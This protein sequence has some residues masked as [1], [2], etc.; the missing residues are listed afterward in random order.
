MNRKILFAT[1]FSDASEEAF[2]Q[3]CAIGARDGAVVGIC[4]VLPRS[5]A[6]PPWLQ[7]HVLGEGEVEQ[8]TRDA[9]AERAAALGKAGVAKVETFV[10]KGDFHAAIVEQ[11]EAFGADR[12]LVGS[13]GR[14]GVARM[15]LGSVAEK[16]VRH[17]HCAVLVARPSPETGPVVAS[18]DLSEASKAGLRAAAHEAART[19]S[20]LCAVHVLDVDYPG[21]LPYGVNSAVMVEALQGTEE[22]R[23]TTEALQKILAETAGAF[24]VKATLH[25]TVGDPAASIVQRAEDIGARL[26]VLSTHGR[27]GLSRVLVGSVAEKVVRH[28]HV[29]VLAMRTTSQAA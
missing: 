25:V 26:V 21:G 5:N 3:A 11:A 14:T 22:L 23:E 9:L 6:V 1:D 2:R 7:G 24:G 10:T 29:S 27:T 28:A 20:E 15:L 4:H 13:H 16:V 12:I 19:A 18:T 17:A 8:R